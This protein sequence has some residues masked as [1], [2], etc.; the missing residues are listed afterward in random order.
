MGDSI[1]QTIVERLKT[2][3]KPNQRIAHLSG[4]NFAILVTDQADSKAFELTA[5]QILEHVQQPLSHLNELVII[6]MHHK[7]P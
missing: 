5:T 1:L 4:D 3:I 2:V 6:T 7:S